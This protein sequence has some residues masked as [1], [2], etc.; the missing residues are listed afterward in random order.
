MQWQMFGHQIT[1]ESFITPN[2]LLIHSKNRTF[3]TL[4]SAVPRFWSALSIEIRVISEKW[5]L[6]NML[7]VVDELLVKNWATSH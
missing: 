6:Q 1:Y 7:L 2:V 4:R 3:E 5:A